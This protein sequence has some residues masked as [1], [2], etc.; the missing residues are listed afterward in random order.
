MAR[1]KRLPVVGVLLAV[2]AAFL[3]T[4]V[5]T[6]VKPVVVEITVVRGKVQGGTKRPTVAKGRVVRFVVRTDAGE[7][8]H[9]HGYEI[10]KTPVAR[11]P[12]VIQ[13]TARI[14]GRFELELHHPDVLL[15]QLTV[16]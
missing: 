2:T 10:K 5:Q 8:V 3:G 15:A 12:T 9:L 6:A 4:T 11:K 16:R 1:V 14:Q 7:G 13:F